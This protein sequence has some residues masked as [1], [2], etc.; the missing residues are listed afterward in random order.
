MPS[1]NAQINGKF[2]YVNAGSYGVFITIHEGENEDSNEW[3]TFGEGEFH[4]CNQQES[5]I[6]MYEYSPNI[7]QY[8]NP[9]E[10]QLFQYDTLMDFSTMQA[11]VHLHDYIQ[12]SGDL[13]EDEDVERSIIKCID[14]SY[15]QS[16]TIV[17][18]DQK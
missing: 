3:I 15:N 2:I 18:E 16:Y 8:Y 17:L 11:L 1:I 7:I 4:M 9:T 6:E 13:T 14:N 5:N 10:E 12:S